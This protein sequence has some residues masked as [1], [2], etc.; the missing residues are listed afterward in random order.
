[1]R[2]YVMIGTSIDAAVGCFP[3]LACIIP[4]ACL[5]LSSSFMPESKAVSSRRG[6]LCGADGGQEPRAGGVSI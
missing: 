6:A 3:S 1:M 4:H 2:S 5:L